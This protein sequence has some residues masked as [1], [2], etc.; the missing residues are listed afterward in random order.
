MFKKRNL[1]IVIASLGEKTYLK[2]CLQA[3]NNQSILPAKIILVLPKG[4]IFKYNLKNLEIYNSKVKNQVFQRNL[5]ISKLD[6]DIK[7]LL[8]LDDRVILKKDA[9]GNLLRSWNQNNNKNVAGIGLNPIVPKEEYNFKNNNFSLLDNLFLILSNKFGFFKPGS[10]LLNGM[11]LQY[12]NLEKS[13]N[14]SWLK[15]GLSSYDL[16]KV[17]KIIYNRKFPKINWSVCEDLIFSYHFSKKYNLLVCSSAKVKLQKKVNKSNIIN[18]YN[19]GKSYSQNLKYFVKINKNLSFFLYFLSTLSLSFFGI[20]TG[21]F[22][23][24]FIHVARNL[25]RLMGVFSKNLFDS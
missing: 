6:K 12:A 13:I 23:F 25:G 9:I 21:L 24:N 4:E 11:C 8:Q 14:V 16:S 3:I 22:S 17:K 5:G 18:E 10:V 20:I 19:L 15:G 1:A 7:L 2:R